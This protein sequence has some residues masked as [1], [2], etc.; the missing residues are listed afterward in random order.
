MEPLTKSLSSQ[1][2]FTRACSRFAQRRGTLDISPAA[3]SRSGRIFAN[4]KN[5]P[6]P[7]NYSKLRSDNLFRSQLENATYGSFYTSKAGSH[8]GIDTKPIY[9]PSP[10]IGLVSQVLIPFLTLPDGSYSL[11]NSGDT[12]FNAADMRI[13]SALDEA[14]R[15]TPCALRERR[16]LHSGC[17][18]HRSSAGRPRSDCG[19]AT[20]CR[21]CGHGP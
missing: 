20:S 14:R 18:V 6:L 13:L 7:R 15:P 5:P 1:M 12:Q 19:H 11:T 21:C 16:A 8:Y 17:G 9:N 2:G 10:E 4:R 3:N